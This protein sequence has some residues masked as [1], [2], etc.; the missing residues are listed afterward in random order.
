MTTTTVLVN[1]TETVLDARRVRKGDTLTGSRGT[2]TIEAN[3]RRKRV[4]R[5]RGEGWKF[6]IVRSYASLARV[7]GA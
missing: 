5:L 6:T 7:I 3:A 2:F 1:A 4:V